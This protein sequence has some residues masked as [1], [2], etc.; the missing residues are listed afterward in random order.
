MK[1]EQVCAIDDAKGPLVVT[2]RENTPVITL[3]LLKDGRFV[4]VTYAR[5]DERDAEG[6]PI[7]R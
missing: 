6:R 1:K 7:Y 2:V 5:T 3:V 4:N